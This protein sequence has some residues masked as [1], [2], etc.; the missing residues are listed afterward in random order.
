MNFFRLCAEALFPD[1]CVGCSTRG[2]LLCDSCMKKL[3]PAET[4]AHDFISSVYAYRDGRVRTL[5][6]L[7]KYKQA[8]RVAEIFADGLA[9]LATEH[10]GEEGPFIS[11]RKIILVPV[12]LS[13][14]RRRSRGFNQA[15]LLARAMLR[16]LS[17][18]RFEIR[19][20]LLFKK[21]DTLA[22][23]EI[24]K[25][26]ERLVNLKNSFSAEALADT[27]ALIILIDDVTTTGAT[28]LECKRALYQ[29]GYRNIRAITV[30]R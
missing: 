15:E 27:R 11:R 3:P 14:K 16:K 26:S 4:S 20:D 28:L 6:R 13:K 2:I 19:T 29:S 25:R 7:L 24:K 5:I 12:P 21:S 30:A 22:Q 1:R 18:G 17:E 8:R 23:A 10:L 9:L